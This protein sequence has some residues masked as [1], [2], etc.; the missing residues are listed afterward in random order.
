[1]AYPDAT[2]TPEY[3]PVHVAMHQ[4]GHIRGR[5]VPMSISQTAGAAAV[6]S[7]QYPDHLA[8]HGQFFRVRDGNRLMRR[9]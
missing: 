8:P 9:I 4:T 3:T 5:A 6:P 1:M 2:D 7:P